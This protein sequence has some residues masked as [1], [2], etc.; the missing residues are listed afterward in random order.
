MQELWYL[1]LPYKST[2]LFVVVGI[3]TQLA[4]NGSVLRQRNDPVVT[5][6]LVRQA[7]H[8][9]C[10]LGGGAVMVIIEYPLNNRRADG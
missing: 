6:G 4:G 10:P 5:G 2:Y 1:H 9:G 3:S 8:C 7:L